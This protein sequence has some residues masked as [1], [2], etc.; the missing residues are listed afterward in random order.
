MKRILLSII[1]VFSI[2]AQFSFAQDAGEKQADYSNASVSIRFYDRTMYYP[3]SKEDN[4][5]YV[6][7]A[8]TNK[9]TD[10][11]RFK[12]ADDRMFSLDFYAYTIKNT[13][14]PNTKDLTIKRSTNQTVY[15]RELAIE[16]GETYSFVENVKDYIQIDEPSIY[17]LE[18]RFY[19]ELYKSRMIE[20]ASNRLSLDIRPAPSASSSNILPVENKTMALLKPEAISPDKVVEQTITARQKSLWDQYF[21]YMDIEQMMVRNSEVN[22]KYK[23]ASAD[24]RNRMLKVYKADLM[25]N[26]IDYDIVSIPERFQIENT[27]YSQTEGTVSVIEWF[28][29]PNFSEKKR[30]IYKVRQR[31]GIWQIYDYSVTNLGTE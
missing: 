30:Y 15:F 3:G 22:R 31:D 24:E 2:F 28:K 10:T 29:Y 1:T 26:R 25:Q 13:T 4:P 8:I 19:P 17:Y 21:L 9:G 11:L 14:L 7:V 23:N 27:S 6:D 18:M 16:P 12:L 20:I 5:I